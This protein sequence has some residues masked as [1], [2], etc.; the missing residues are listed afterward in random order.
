MSN[1]MNPMFRAICAVVK[2]G[3]MLFSAFRGT[4]LR[5]FEVAPGAGRASVLAAAAIKPRRCMVGFL[6]LRRSLDGSAC[7]LQGGSARRHRRK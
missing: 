6:R 1:T 4:Q 7:G 3:S 2:I 5:V